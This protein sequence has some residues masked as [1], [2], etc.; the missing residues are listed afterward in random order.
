MKGNRLS[1]YLEDEEMLKYWN[2]SV[3]KLGKEN[4]KS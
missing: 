1:L 4:I 2:I 3:E